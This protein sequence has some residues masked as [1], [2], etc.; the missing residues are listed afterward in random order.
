M[1][2]GVCVKAGHTQSVAVGAQVFGQL[3]GQQFF[4]LFR[5]A[6]YRLDV[7]VAAVRAGMWHALMQATVVAAQAAVYFVKHAVRAAMRA[8]AFPTAV[9]AAEHGRVAAAVQQQ[10]ALFAALRA[11]GNSV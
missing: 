9:A 10:Q 11:L 7:N 4:K 8:L 5:A 3:V 6:T 2:S 1:A